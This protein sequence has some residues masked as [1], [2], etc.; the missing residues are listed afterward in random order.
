MHLE[1]FF[2][3]A[4]AAFGMVLRESSHRGS[5]DLDLV[6]RLAAASAGADATGYRSE[7]RELVESTRALLP[8]LP[9]EV[10]PPVKDALSQLQMAFVRESQQPEGEPEAPAEPDDQAEREKARSK[11]WTPPGT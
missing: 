9:D 7:L 1:N 2:A 3:A 5:A 6:S 10:Q 8:L 4:V 11:I